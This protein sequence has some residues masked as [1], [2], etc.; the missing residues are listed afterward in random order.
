MCVVLDCALNEFADLTIGECVACD[1]SCRS[2]TDATSTGCKSCP[3]GYGLTTSG[4]CWIC[5]QTN[6]LRLN[7]LG[8][9][10]ETCGDG[11]KTLAI[12]QCDD[13]NTENGDGCDDECRVEEGWS[14]EGG[15]ETSPD[16]CVS[17]S[18]PA[19]IIET[20]HKNPEI[21]I[22]KFDREIINNIKESEIYNEISVELS[23]INVEDSQY[24]ITYDEE[25]QE[26]ELEFF[27]KRSLLDS[28]LAI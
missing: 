25:A 27:L 26:Y 28:T 23:G 17:L 20:D 13:A 9:C 3:D 4:S 22:L 18:G 19:L 12:T 24:N 1:A 16:Y 11:Y 14:C 8:V 15:D 10:Y 5:D 21:V 6:D 2:C 7:S